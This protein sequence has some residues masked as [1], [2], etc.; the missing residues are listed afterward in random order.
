MTG[1]GKQ[2]IFIHQVSRDRMNVQGR[3]R[4]QRFHRRALVGLALS[5]SACQASPSLVP[6]LGAGGGGPAVTR[7]QA[8]VTAPSTAGPSAVKG[9]RDVVG[10]TMVL[11]I[12][13][14]ARRTQGVLAETDLLEILPEEFVAGDSRP[15]KLLEVQRPEGGGAIRQEITLQFAPEVDEAAV[16]VKA[17]ALGVNGARI[18]KGQGRGN[19]R[20]RRDTPVALRIT[21]SPAGEPI[22][23]PDH[24]E[25]ILRSLEGHY[26]RKYAHLVDVTQ[27]PEFSA[28]RLA[29]EDLIEKVMRGFEPERPPQEPDVPIV[30]NPETPTI[31]TLGQFFRLL[32]DVEPV[33]LPGPGVEPPT[34]GNPG[35]GDPPPPERFPA[36]PDPLKGIAIPGL[37]A[38]PD[39][40]VVVDPTMGD[41]L[42]GLDFPGYMARIDGSRSE[43]Q[44]GRQGDLV[45]DL[46]PVAGN[47]P[48]ASGLKLHFDLKAL[49]AAW[50]TTGL[51]ERIG[52][53]GASD[54]F[55]IPYLQD[56]P[57]LARIRSVG[58]NFRAAPASMPEATVSFGIDLDRFSAAPVDIPG[59][60]RGL[61]N[62]FS[63]D[64]VRIP[65][66]LKGHVESPW[67][68]IHGS[69]SLS[70]DN[71]VADS[72]GELAV[73]DAAGAFDPYPYRVLVDW[74]GANMRSSEGVRIQLR[75]DDV[76]NG[77]GLRAQ[78]TSRGFDAPPE[79]VANLVDSSTEKRLG[80]IE[81]PL[82]MPRGGSARLRD[83]PLLILEPLGEGE[84]PIQYRLTPGFFSGD[85]TG[86]LY[87]EVR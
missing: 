15:G 62:G 3:S 2:L 66:S 12:Q 7:G 18:L 83:Y 41:R 6:G 21:L 33:P 57:D 9:P 24:Q 14:P 1:S 19:E 61:W 54:S 35:A 32:E 30:E 5:L 8:A 78:I 71:S 22:V 76:A 34:V 65:L 26:A 39:T 36:F 27:S 84:A 70:I 53:P 20:L 67:A 87:V 63:F 50:M 64:G 13:W 77:F 17:Y 82:E 60:P 74:S 59:L 42:R 69:T 43:S 16:Q 47:L 85:R 52:I 56:A 68:R 23:V 37:M 86:A 72:S 38:Y 25:R 4:M 73:R 51:P 40:R 46:V 44:L 29:G 28:Y 48:R 81:F 45:F 31:G 75:A 10:H 58:A 80:R 11:T 55:A 79:V 49:A